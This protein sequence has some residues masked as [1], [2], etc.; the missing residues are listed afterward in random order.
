MPTSES[1]M[2]RAPAAKLSSGMAVMGP[3]ATSR[4]RNDTLALAHDPWPFA[5]CIV[6]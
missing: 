2:R 1:G 4:P 3:A 6:K 5:D